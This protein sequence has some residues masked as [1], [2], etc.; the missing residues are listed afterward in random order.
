M[1]SWLIFRQKRHQ[2]RLTNSVCWNFTGASRAPP[3]RL[4]SQ[5]RDFHQRA[6][7]REYEIM[8]ESALSAVRRRFD[9]L[10]SHRRYRR[11]ICS[12][13]GAELKWTRQGT[14]KMPRMKSAMDSSKERREKPGRFNERCFWD[15]WKKGGGKRGKDLDRRLDVVSR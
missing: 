2:E 7:T 13:R 8:C 14:S 3:L 1:T 9:R 5:L 4:V 6:Q 11:E 12:E 15:E 10:N